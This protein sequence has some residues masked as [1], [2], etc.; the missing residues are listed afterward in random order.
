MHVPIAPHGGEL[1]DLS[2]PDEHRRELQASAREMAEVRLSEWELSDLEMLCVG[3]LSPL[4]GFMTKA[5]YESVTDHMRLADGTLWSLPIVL[6]APD[7]D[8]GRV[9]EGDKVA[10][11][12]RAGAVLA[13]MS[14]EGVFNRQKEREA[15]EVYRTTDEKHPGVAAVYESGD[16]LIGGPV[17]M[18]APVRH[19][20]FLD[21][22]FTPAETRAEFAR[23]GWRAVVG[24]QTR[25]PIHR[26]HEYLMKCA[27]EIVDG[28]FVNPLMGA[29]KADDVPADIRMQ[30]Y[31]TLLAEYFPPGRT[32]MGIF[33]AAM[34]YAGPREAVF[35]A[36][37]RKNY[38]CTHFI[39]GRDHAGVG[40]YYGTFDAQLIF[41]EFDPADIGI[42]PLFFDY[43]FYCRKCGEMASAKTCPHDKSR[44][45]SLSGTKV[46]AMLR[47]GELPPPEFT[48]PEIA[49][50]L[51]DAMR[52]S[53]ANDAPAL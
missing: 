39:V 26:A 43:A 1:V 29:T 37:V 48:R 5:D 50:I 9:K 40:D 19:D 22:R 24:F 3:A 6:S 11:C 17:R 34:R 51:I 53:E 46:R 44:H 13:V 2:V 4:K 36:I 27:L 12:D 32:F 18:L 42:T 33:P 41:N 31:R 35:H 38:G 30:C 16:T 21:C 28:L 25:N 20:D 23:R 14:V 8:S 47:R 49:G 7:D 15:K 10:L 45:V 52:A